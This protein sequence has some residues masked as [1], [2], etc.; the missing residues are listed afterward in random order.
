MTRRSR[1][2]NQWWRTSESKPKIDAML[3]KASSERGVPI[4]PDDLDKDF[5]LLNVTNGT[6]D[7]RGGLLRAHRREDLITRLAPV[8]FHPEAK[9]PT[10]LAVLEKIFGRDK[11][12]IKFW[13][14][15][16]GVCLTGDVSP[17]ILPVLYGAAQNGKST[18]LN[19]LLEIL[20]PDYAIA[21]PPGLLTLKKGERH[22]TE[23]ASL[24]NKRLVV[25]SETAEGAQFN[26]T[27]VK[28]LTGGDKIS[29]RRMKEDFWEFKPTHKILMCTN[30][31]PEIRETKN[32]IWRRVKLVPF[33]VTIPTDEQDPRLP[34]KLRA[35]YPG[36]LAWC[37]EGC[38]DWIELGLEIPSAVE[39]ATKEYRLE[40][41]VIGEFLAAECSVGDAY[42]VRAMPLYLRYQKWAGAEA[43]NQ[44]KFGKAMTE[45]G[46]KKHTNNGTEYLGLGLRPEGTE[47]QNWGNNASVA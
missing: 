42:R 8:E 24:F 10:W 7:L 12:L 39:D 14:M 45:R 17:Q 30:H 36:I 31:K 41:D 33:N 3:S 25:D 20:G 2:H 32:A 4:L 5:F 15:L 43:I 46:F 47:G 22:P 18:I 23:L 34:E 29:A 13:K 9:C 35:E 1:R 28:Q 6:I 40:S 26:E 44:R 37:V 19:V 16:C 21:A 38:L 27:L 11:D